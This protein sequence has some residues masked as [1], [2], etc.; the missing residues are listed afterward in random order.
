MTVQILGSGC[1]KC[2][3]LEKQAREAIAALGLP[4]EIEKISDFERISALGVMV[5]PAFAI[6]NVVKSVGKVLSKDQIVAF[7][8]GETIIKAGS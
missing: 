6:N 2:N 5:T 7:I 8:R 4:I 3:L 1:A